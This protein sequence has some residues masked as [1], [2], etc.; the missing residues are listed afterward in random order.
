MVS[1]KRTG[2]GI[3]KYEGGLAFF[4]FW[5]LQV[6]PMDVRSHSLWPTPQ[7]QQHQILA[8][9]AA[10]T[11][12]HGNARSLTHWMRPGLKP[13]S[14]WILAGFVTAEPQWELQENLSLNASFDFLPVKL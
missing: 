5:G 8:E 13:T 4:V 11:K 2:L 9:S 3:R 7:P 1:R 10:Y 12:A 6:Q 14:S